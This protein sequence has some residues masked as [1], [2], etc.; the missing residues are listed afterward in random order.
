MDPLNTQSTG[1]SI[2]FFACFYFQEMRVALTNSSLFD[3]MR[4]YGLHTILLNST[5]NCEQRSNDV[6]N[7]RDIK[8]LGLPQARSF[9]WS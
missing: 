8:I 5:V 1:E 4:D 9:H 6:Q 7:A 3:M 2:K